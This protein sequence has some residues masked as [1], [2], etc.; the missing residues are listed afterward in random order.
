MRELNEELCYF[1]AAEL[2]QHLASHSGADLEIEGGTVRGELFVV[3]NIPVKALTI[4]EGAL[5]TVPPEE[6]KQIEDRLTPMTRYALK[7]FG[8]LNGDTNA[9]DMEKVW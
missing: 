4:T 3:R 2:F 1:V 9:D 5:L 7:A 6:L 8:C